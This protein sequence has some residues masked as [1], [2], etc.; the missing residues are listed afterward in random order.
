VIAAFLARMSRS[1]PSADLRAAQRGDRGAIGRLYDEHVD[2][3]YI[4]VA[5][6]FER[7]DRHADALPFWEHA[8]TVDPRPLTRMSWPAQRA[9]ALT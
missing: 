5:E 6:D 1:I 2:A 9:V 3:L 8:I 4:A 7:Q